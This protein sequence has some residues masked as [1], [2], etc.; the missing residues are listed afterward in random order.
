MT[1]KESDHIPYLANV[2]SMAFADSVLSPPEN[3]AIE[4]IRNRIGAKKSSL[5]IAIKTVQL[6]DFSQ[7]RVGDFATQ[8]CN[9]ADMLYVSY[10]DGGLDA[11]EKTILIDFCK[12]VGLTQEQVNTMV[13]QAISRVDQ[14]KLKLACPH[15]KTDVEASAKFCSYCGKPTDSKESVTDFVAFDVPTLGYAIEFCESTAASFPTALQLAKSSPGFS[16]QSRNRKSWHLATWPDSD[17]EQVTKL[18]DLL[19]GIRNRKVYK[20]G[21]EVAWNDLFGFVWCANERSKAYRPTQYCFGKGDGQI[22]PCGCRH[23][24]LDWTGWAE[25]LTYGKFVQTGQTAYW[26]FDKDRIRHEMMTSL[27]RYRY[28]PFLRMKLI[29]SV[30]KHLPEKIEVMKDTR[31]GLKE[32]YDDEPGA[33]TV[34]KKTEFGRE[35]TKYDGVRPKGIEMIREILT[36]AFKECGIA[37][38]SVDEITK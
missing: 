16:T 31:W 12:K 38:V 32:C 33:M 13:K 9:I 6:G 37:D 29:E 25:W 23:A 10:V 8:V 24:K 21:K 17:F 5:T 15:C 14:A 28:C 35:E 26:A 18:A 4:E 30:L 27:H 2:I 36:H 7:T 1:L 3:A 19:S 11:N 22:N 34:V 20:D